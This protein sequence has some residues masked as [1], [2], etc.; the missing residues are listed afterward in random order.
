MLILVVFIM[1]I[2]DKICFEFGY[3]M[4]LFIML[5]CEVVFFKVKCDRWDVGWNLY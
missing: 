4:K 1:V 2:I 3:K 5:D